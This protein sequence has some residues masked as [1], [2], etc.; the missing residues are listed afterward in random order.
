MSV[1]CNKLCSSPMAVPRWLL[2]LDKFLIYYG[3]INPVLILIKI[4]I[5]KWSSI[6]EA[7]TLQQS[8]HKALPSAQAPLRL[9]CKS[10]LTLLL[11]AL[12]SFVG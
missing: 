6:E 8:Q 1:A 2:D 9:C 7:A 11:H 3:T 4:L 12:M 5:N 10:V